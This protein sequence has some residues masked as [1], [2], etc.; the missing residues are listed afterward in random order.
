MSEADAE[1]GSSKGSE[2]ILVVDDRQSSV[3]LTRRLLGKGG[4]TKVRSATDSR[5]AMALVRSWQPALVLLD[6]H[7][8]HM[9]GTE[10]LERLRGDEHLSGVKV[11]VVTADDD[12]EA[13]QRARS[14]GASGVV[15]K[16]VDVAELLER[17]GALLQ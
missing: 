10:F 14:A 3:L 2:R 12:P 5:A 6:L 15:T 7:M 8:P 17:V 16:P 13:L 1:A 11:L 4:Y 9:G